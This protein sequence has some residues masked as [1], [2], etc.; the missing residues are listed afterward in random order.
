M[1]YQTCW[2]EVLDRGQSEPLNPTYVTRATK[3]A[4]LDMLSARFSIQTLTRWA[5]SQGAPSRYIDNCWVRVEVSAQQLLEFLTDVSP[6]PE[7]VIKDIETRIS[8]ALR[9][10]IVA[11]EF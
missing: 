4:D 9:Y 2:I 5:A 10:V 6:A 7:T 3:L 1:T 11:E 8:Q